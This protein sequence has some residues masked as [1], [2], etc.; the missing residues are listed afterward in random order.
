MNYFGNIRGTLKCYLPAPIRAVLRAALTYAQRVGLWFIILWQVRGVRWLDQWIL[1]R[2]AL[3]APLSALRKPLEWQDPILLADAEV[4]VQG[5]GRF[6]LRARCDDLY[7]VLPWRERAIM[8][9]MRSQ[10]R[11]GDSFID[12]G[13]N[14]GAHTVLASRLVGPGGKVLAVEM[15][16]DTGDRLQG[17]VDLNELHNVT[18]VRAALSDVDGE[19]V[20]ATV[21][22]GMY[23]QASIVKTDIHKS[24][25]TRILVMTIT[26]NTISQAFTHVKMMKMDLEGAELAALR[27]GADLL[28]LVD[29]VIYERIGN[30][31]NLVDAYLNQSAFELSII[32][33]SNWLARRIDGPR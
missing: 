15:M 3:S 2:S 10:L 27:G 11:S 17:N 14:I 23:G 32:D 18:I 25:M 5:V 24:A 31:T 6:R 21:E 7:S 4:Q 22:P 12:A 28:K 33:D 29:F 8:A 26:L 30:D 1:F 13:A 19:F 9:M 20:T 16:P